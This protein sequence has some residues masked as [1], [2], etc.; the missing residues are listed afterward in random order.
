MEDNSAELK[1]ILEKV[2]SDISLFQVS[3][4]KS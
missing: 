3:K 4:V 1:G 2:S